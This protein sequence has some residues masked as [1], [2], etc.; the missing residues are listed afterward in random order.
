MKDIQIYVENRT[1][2]NLG[3]KVCY[4]G[5][6]IYIEIGEKPDKEVGTYI[7][8]DSHNANSKTIKSNL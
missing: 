4:C 7:E 1:S 5:D 8:V 3:V 6:L 2:L